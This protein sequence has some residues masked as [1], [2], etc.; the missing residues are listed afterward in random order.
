MN[1]PST[2]TEERPDS[3]TYPSVFKW[4]A[5]D[6]PDR[7]ATHPDVNNGLGGD[8]PRL[9]MIQFENG[10]IK[11]T[12]TRHPQTALHNT[13]KLAKSHDTWITGAL[14]SHPAPGLVRVRDMLLNRLAIAGY[15]RLGKGVL[16]A[17]PI[18]TVI[19]ALRQL[20]PDME[21]PVRSEWMC[22][23]EEKPVPAFLR[24]ESNN[25]SS[26][27][28]QPQPHSDD[29]L[30]PVLAGEIGG[31]PCNVCD[32]RALHG[33]MEVGKDFSNWIKD[34]IEKYEFVDGE[35]FS[36]VETL[37]SPN[38]ASSKARRQRVIDYH[39][40]LDMAKELS[41]VEN[42]EKGRQ[43]RRYFIECERRVLEE[44][45]RMV[46]GHDEIERAIDS[47]IWRLAE[48]ERKRLMGLLGNNQEHE[49]PVW[50]M[51][52]RMRDNFR[53]TMRHMV[54]TQW[55]KQPANLV[56]ASI[57]TWKPLELMAL[58]N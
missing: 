48:E 3:A 35:D 15:H 20:R 37:S 7:I 5:W 49:G 14:V 11:I 57:A 39:L 55:R 42:N 50:D 45:P 47:R 28:A 32:A 26:A 33:F 4:A 16:A 54:N 10:A 9:M 13:A 58:R 41:M 31:V 52:Y 18:E 25:M 8:F 19:D 17:I 21:E 40:T 46:H 53:E 12:A 36:T 29:G 30:I 6:T 44:Q 51:A 2:E 34:R 1:H 23:K 24:K 22:R 27:I 43:A 38:L 56:L